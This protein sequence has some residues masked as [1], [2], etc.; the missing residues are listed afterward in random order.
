MSLTLTEAEYQR[1]HRQIILPGWGVEGQ[2]K[3]KEAV[4][5]IAGAGGLGSPVAIYLAAA[6]VGK[7]RIC[8]DSEPEISNLN[9]QF[10]HTDSDI[11][12]KKALSAKEMLHKVNPHV[13]I[14]PLPFRIERENVDELIGNARIIID[15]MDNF[16]TRH[17][18]NEYAVR[19]RMPFVHGGVIGMCGQI[20]FIHSPETP[21]L[22]CIFP[23]SPPREVFPVV[24]ATPGVI[25]TLEALEVLKYITGIGENLKGRL[26]IWD[27]ERMEFQQVPVQKYPGCPVCS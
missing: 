24:G 14:E 2:E 12:K 22:H 10:L 1:Y 11:G 4:V 20:T 26:L 16:P 21:C 25:G 23:G 18:L 7:I 19:K 8:D 13:K 3:V 5:F 27:G 6:G 17:I 15:C 9:R